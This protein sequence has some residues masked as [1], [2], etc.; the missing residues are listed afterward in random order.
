MS[1]T[2]D[3]LFSRLHNNKKPF[4]K[5]QGKDKNKEPEEE[6]YVYF[7]NYAAGAPIFHNVRFLE[8]VN[9]AGMKQVRAQ[10]RAECE[11][12][13]RAEKERRREEIM[14]ELNRPF[15]GY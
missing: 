14:S 11:D 10:H 8:V 15:M 9:E 6:L 13:E 3:N 7:R 4:S 1:I 5:N 2:R 12:R